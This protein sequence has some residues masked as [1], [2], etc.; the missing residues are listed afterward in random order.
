MNNYVLN[1]YYVPHAKLRAGDKTNT[2]FPAFKGLSIAEPWQH[3]DVSPI[4][5]RERCLHDAEISHRMWPAEPWRARGLSLRRKPGKNI[6]GGKHHTWEVLG[7]E[8]VFGARRRFHYGQTART[9]AFPGKVPGAA[10]LVCFSYHR[11]VGM[12]SCFLVGAGRIFS[13]SPEWVD[14]LVNKIDWA[15]WLTSDVQ[16]IFTLMKMSHCF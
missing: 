16:S 3:S 7:G 1:T 6:L 10:E 4:P 12:F 11:C 13:H 14:H 9:W 5:G 8:R 2:K 15:H